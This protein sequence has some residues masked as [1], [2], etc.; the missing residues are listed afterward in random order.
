MSCDRREQLATACGVQGSIALQCRW[1]TCD[2]YVIK[3]KNAVLTPASL[4]MSNVSRWTFLVACLLD[5]W[6][7]F[8]S[9]AT[10]AFEPST[11]TAE[12]VSDDYALRHASSSIS[13]V[14]P[15]P[16]AATEE[17][18]TSSSSA[19]SAGDEPAAPISWDNTHRRVPPY[20]PI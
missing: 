4:S 14:K 19:T 2:E 13:D 18:F 17:S 12:T 9:A 8:R 6:C 1:Y 11:R 5:I 15:E 3:T 16:A 10:R 7:I 20:K